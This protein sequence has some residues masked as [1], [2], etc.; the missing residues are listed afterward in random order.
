M[1]QTFADDHKIDEL[2]EK[3]PAGE[4]RCFGL[5]HS[6]STSLMLLFVKCFFHLSLSLESSVLQTWWHMPLSSRGIL[7]PDVD[8]LLPNHCKEI[9]FRDRRLVLHVGTRYYAV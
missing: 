2:V 5:F 9:C 1:A 4:L 3:V 6:F 8:I 7:P